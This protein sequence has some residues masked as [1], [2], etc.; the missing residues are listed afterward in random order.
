MGND[1]SKGIVQA[2]EQFL[3]RLIDLSK[4]RLGRRL[5]T[6]QIFRGRSLWL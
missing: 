6:H 4:E 1:S 2:L 5:V 3:R